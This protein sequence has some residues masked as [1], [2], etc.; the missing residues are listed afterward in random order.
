M[1]KLIKVLQNTK[2]N[3]KPYDGKDYD[4]GYQSIRINNILLKGQRDCEGRL[5]FFK[6]Y[7]DFKDKTVLDIGCY[8]GGMLFPLTEIKEGVGIDVSELNINGANAIKNYLNKINL[9]FQVFNLDN[10]KL[11]LLNGLFKNTKIEIAFVLS[12]CMWIK[13]WKE[14]IDFLKNN[15]EIVIFESNGNV[16]QQNEQIQY[17]KN[18]FKNVQLISENSFDNIVSTGRKLLICTV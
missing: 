10:D 12:I 4:I 13:K 8:Y 14:L 18:K 5:N 17:L 9:S 3:N 11:S 16:I 7:V 15:V 1:D 6:K 2:N